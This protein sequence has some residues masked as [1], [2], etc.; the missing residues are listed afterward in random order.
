[1]TETYLYSGIH[2][3]LVRT[4]IQLDWD[5]PDSDD[6]PWLV[7]WFVHLDKD[8]DILQV[9]AEGGGVGENDPVP[10]VASHGQVKEGIVGYRTRNLERVHKNY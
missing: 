10:P 2:C 9:E 7:A 4:V 8:G 6:V 3:A 5:N 1:M